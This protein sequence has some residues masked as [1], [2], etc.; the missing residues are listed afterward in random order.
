M[1]GRRGLALGLLALTLNAGWLWAFAEASFF[2]VANVLGH[3]VGGLLLAA[4][5]FFNRKLIAE[6]WNE[7]GK[8]ALVLLAGGVLTGLALCV[9]GATRRNVNL[10][11]V[12]GAAGFLGAAFVYWFARERS[13]SLFRWGWAALAV[14][15]LLPAGE[16]LRRDLAPSAGTERIVNPVTAPLTME[17]EGGGPESPF[18]PAPATTNVGGKIPANFFLDSEACGECHE[19]IYEQWQ[20]SMHHFSS[21]NNQFYRK[22]IEYM[23]ETA[24]VQPSKWC[25]G[26]HDHAMLFDGLFDTPVIEQI[27]TP[28]AQA[29]LGCMSCHSI[30][31]VDSTMG[32]AAFEMTYPGLH[33]LMATENP[34]LQAINRYVTN[35]APKAHRKAFLKPFM[36]LDSAEFCSSCHKVHLDK[37]V[38]NYR[39][40]RGFNS[41]DNWQASGVSGHGARSFYYPIASQTCNDC[42]MPLVP[43]DDPGAVDGLVRSHHFAAANTAVPYVN[44]DKEQL[45]RVVDFLQSDIVSVDIFAV[46]EVGEDSF[47]QARQQAAE[48]G[49]GLATTFGVGEEAAAGGPIVIREVGA[50]AAPIDRANPTLTPGSSARVDVVVRTKRVGHVFPSGTVDAFDVWVELRAEDAAG[51]TI[52]WSGRVEDDGKGDVEKGAHFYRSVMLDA[53]GNRI[54]KRNAFHART[55]L[56]A[57]LIPP[58][59]ADVARFI[60]EVPEDAEGPIK[61]HAKVNYRKF[62]RSYTAF[63]YAGLGNDDGEFGQD[64][65]DRSFDYSP[66]NIPENVSGE[67]KD[68]I[69]NLPIVTLAEHAAEI[70]LSDDPTPFE[71]QLH[72]EDHTRWNDYG[73]G[74]LLQG[75]IRAAQ[76]AFLRATEIKPDFADGW[77]N[78]ARALLQEGEADE[79]L[80]YIEKALEIDDSLGRIHFFKAL[81]EKAVGD[82]DSALASLQ[83][84]ESLYPRDRVVLNQLARVLF[85]GRRYQE[86][87]R[88]LERVARIDP[89]DLQMHY[90]AMLC[91]RGLGDNEA[92]ERERLLFE[93]FKADED[94]QML[95][96]DARRAAPED[97]NER[98][99]IHEHRSVDLSRAAPLDSSDF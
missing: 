36:R 63:A 39:W 86:A 30:T 50:I 56:Y 12:H 65:D 6:M 9:V 60:V 8:A 43:S 10:V 49:P 61:L 24:G 48:S 64:F 29:G 69:P 71:P 79:A 1:I 68:R 20:S 59:A 32:N 13:S 26:C 35:T 76:Y 19:D 97:N 83:R 11:I 74:L 17:E 89:E 62:A 38:N 3:V 82:Y 37:P 84:V 33:E 87:L 58:G 18:F 27:D 77:L 7:H 96:A 92:A 47:A 22:S 80:R 51:R 46:S 5:F 41:Y 70:A 78:V 88:Y 91:Y 94:A 57:R 14:A 21:F 16:A 44:G 73:I 75:D 55:V 66:E 42:H 25:A 40:F 67:I 95:T 72:D 15:L 28:E 54:D 85:L 2:Y 23:Q 81:V 52:F 90:T 4:A 93:R 45:K 99:P 34:V 53:N 31:R 98:Q